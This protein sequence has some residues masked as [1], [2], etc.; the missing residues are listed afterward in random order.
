MS[1][2]LNRLCYIV[3]KCTYVRISECKNILLCEED[4]DQDEARFLRLSFF[5]I[6]NEKRIMTACLI[7]TY[8][9]S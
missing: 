2:A 6:W 1:E 9:L 8:L 3:Y 4:Q 5:R 7:V